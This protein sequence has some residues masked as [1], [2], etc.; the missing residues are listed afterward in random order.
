M[1]VSAADSIERFMGGLGVY[2]SEQAISSNNDR[3]LDY[4]PQIQS[5][6]VHSIYQGWQLVQGEL[7]A[8]AP[9]KFIT[10]GNFQS[11][12]NTYLE[13]NSNY[14][15]RPGNYGAYCYIDDVSLIHM[16]D[17]TLSSRIQT[18][19][20]PVQDWLSFNGETANESVDIRVIDAF[21]KTIIEMREPIHPNTKINCMSWQPGIY[22][23]HLTLNGEFA[24]K[25]VLKL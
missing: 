23:I 2:F 10:I 5:T 12:E 13:W 17:T 19:Q 25:K 3:V 4:S 6:E 8:D 11:D 22:Y 1:Y 9:Y 20:N 15:G 18:V 14:S 7:V 16:Q 24:I 21:G